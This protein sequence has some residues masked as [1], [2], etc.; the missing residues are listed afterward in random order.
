MRKI[1]ATA[2]AVMLLSVGGA[3]AQDY[4]APGDFP[5]AG[6]Y[7]AMAAG[8]IDAAVGYF[9]EDAVMVMVPLMDEAPPPW[10]DK[11]ALV[12]R[13]EI[14]AWLS[15]LAADNSNMDIYDLKTAEHR[16]MFAGH[17]HGDHF[18]ELGMDPV[19]SEGA[20]VIVDGLIQ[21]LMWY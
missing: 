15:Y 18:K 12:G 9:A 10:A 6:A 13:E 1:L 16:A 2:V 3:G 20:A 4:V 14:G 17:F 21:G 19:P 11:E 7:A 5:V 8:D